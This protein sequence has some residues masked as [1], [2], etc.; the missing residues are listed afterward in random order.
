[1]NA[2]AYYI[3]YFSISLHY[4]IKEVVKY[5]TLIIWLTPSKGYSTTQEPSQVNKA[6]NTIKKYTINLLNGLNL[7][8]LKFFLKLTWK[9]K[10][11]IAISRATTPP[12]LFGML[13]K[14]A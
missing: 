7:R 10:I 14:I 2:L 8:L 3:A 9:T 1:M 13:R 6:N 5:K 4:S 12:S 11:K